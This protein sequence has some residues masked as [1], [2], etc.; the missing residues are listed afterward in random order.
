MQFLDCSDD[1]LAVALG[2][3]SHVLTMC[4]SF[5]QVPLRYPITF[6]GSRSHISDHI[7]AALAERDRE[8]VISLKSS[9]TNLICLSFISFPL[10]AKG[11][12]RMQFN[13]AVYLLNK[14][15]AQLRWICG[16]HT[17]DLRAT[18]PNLLSLLQ[19]RDSK[20]N[21]N[22]RSSITTKAPR[23]ISQQSDSSYNNDQMNYPQKSLDF[24]SHFDRTPNVCDPIFDALR[25]EYQAERS[26]SP[27]RRNRKKS[28][29]NSNK[30]NEPRPGLGEI[31][32]VP[33][34]FMNKQISCSDFKNFIETERFRHLNLGEEEQHESG[35]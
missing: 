6:F 9:E 27:T 24:I 15:I 1:D 22:T 33:E 13:Y 3:V 10:Y 26:H 25:Q 34:A 19:G 11:K 2:Y 28:G 35:N 8:Y 12:D 21:P 16:Q 32:A 29:T 4:A 5:L 17:P 18:L 31:L 30:T 14:D 23:K 20:E 7:T